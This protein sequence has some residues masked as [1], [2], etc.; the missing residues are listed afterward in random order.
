MTKDDYPIRLREFI[1]YGLG[2]HYLLKVIIIQFAALLLTFQFA[3]PLSISVSSPNI[4]MGAYALISILFIAITF[5]FAH[6]MCSRSL[7]PEMQNWKSVVISALLY[8]VVAAFVVFFGYVLL[9]MAVEGIS[10]I[11]LL[12]IALSFLFVTALAA[13]LT[14]GYHDEFDEELPSKHESNEAID[15]WLETTDWVDE[16]DNTQSQKERLERFE[17]NCENLADIFSAANTIGGQK[18]FKDIESWVSKFDRHN[19]QG[20][21]FVMGWQKDNNDTDQALQTEHNEFQ[22]LKSTLKDMSRK[23]D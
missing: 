12:D 21:E 7:S 5:V 3:R 15:D 8:L 2:P 1:T 14:V 16:D 10:Q 19:D 20:K 6:N 22:R 18:L 11:N 13:I 4:F 23:D 9:I 17:E